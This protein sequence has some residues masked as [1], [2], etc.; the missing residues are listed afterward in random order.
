M[1]RKVVLPYIKFTYLLKC[2]HVSQMY[3]FGAI[4]L[5]LSNTLHTLILIFAGLVE[6]SNIGVGLCI[7]K[8][9]RHMTSEES[10]EI[11][12]DE[13]ADTC[14]KIIPLGSM[15]GRADFALVQLWE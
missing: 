11:F 1:C 10:G 3:Q 12:E 9:T 7:K 2:I 8:L 13:F 5:A 4:V 14:N 6:P 15:A